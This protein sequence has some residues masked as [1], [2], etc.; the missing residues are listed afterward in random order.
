MCE[1]V[2][3][4]FC[5]LIRLFCSLIRLFCRYLALVSKHEELCENADLA[6]D[7]FELHSILAKI[8]TLYEQGGYGLK[9]SAKK[10]KKKK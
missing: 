5:S 7:D 4:L 9:R 1:N 6:E 10:A 3:G 2:V 8:G